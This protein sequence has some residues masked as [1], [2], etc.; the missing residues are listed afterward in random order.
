MA[1]SNPAFS[2]DL[3]PGYEQVFGASPSTTMT[4][5]GTVYKS[6]VL[7]AIL[8][9]TGAWAWTASASQTLAYGMLGVAGIGSLI[10]ALFTIFNPKMAT[11]SAPIYAA[12]EGVLLGS[13]SQVV[14]RL[15]GQ[16]IALQAVTLTCGVLCLM[17]FAYATRIIKVTQ[18]LVVGIMVAT[19]RS[20]YST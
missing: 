11:W 18:K 13:F 3:F 8:L 1:T 20:A 7:L 17:L 14:E 4:V 6:L 16:G 12:C 5:Q 19:G 15:Y 10:A 9:A 2:R